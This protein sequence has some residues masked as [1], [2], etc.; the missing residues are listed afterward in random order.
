MHIGG[1]FLTWKR[2][3]DFMDL[4]FGNLENENFSELDPITWE[5]MHLCMNFLE[6]SFIGHHWSADSTAVGALHTEVIRTQ[7]KNFSTDVLKAYEPCKEFSLMYTD[8]LL[9]EAGLDHFGMDNCESE[10]TQNM[11][12][13]PGESDLEWS[14]RQL[15]LIVDRYVFPVLSG[16]SKLPV[17]QETETEVKVR[18]TPV[19]LANGEVVLI[20]FND[21]EDEY[22]SDSGDDSDEEDAPRVPLHTGVQVTRV[23]REVRSDH[24][25]NYF[26]SILEC[27]MVFKLLLEFIKTPHRES[28]LRLFKLMT[29]IMKG[30]SVNA[31][32]PIALITTLVQQYSIYPL[33]EACQTLQA[34]FANTRGKPDTHVPVDMVNEWGVRAQKK[35]NIHAGP[36]KSDEQIYLQSAALPGLAEIGERWDEEVNAVHRSHRHHKF[37]DPEAF[38][39]LLEDIHQ[40]LPFL[41]IED[42]CLE[43]FP[44]IFASLTEALDGHYLMAWMREKME[45]LRPDDVPA[46]P[47]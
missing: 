23:F 17:I 37:E 7:R 6:G 29:I 9:I 42:R 28:L 18:G 46:A 15:G 36:N 22:L 21:D 30:R 4:F 1:D 25:K 24:K 20:P 39:V 5:M 10:P 31:Q 12:R 33:N 27:G 19:T 40:A 2:F 16:H 43:D 47:N 11:D 35:N 41:H 13:L 14:K 44:R 26:H 3:V 8:A 38:A 34:C 32:Y 45:D